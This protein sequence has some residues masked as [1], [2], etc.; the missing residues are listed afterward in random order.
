MR[1]LNL[2]VCM[3]FE[4]DWC[5]ATTNNQTVG[6]SGRGF[7]LLEP[8]LL[9]ISQDVIRSTWKTLPTSIEQQV[10]KLLRSVERPVIARHVGERAQIEAQ[11]AMQSII[12]TQVAIPP[13][14]MLCCVDNQEAWAN[15]Y[16]G[17]LSPPTR[18]KYI[19][20][21]KRSLKTM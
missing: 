21:T 7:G 5:L 2:M 9:H 1:I 16:R 13:A 4:A 19:S 15:V 6:I 8:Q 10:Q 12:R 17:C 11:V 14:S 20:T 18:R 3:C